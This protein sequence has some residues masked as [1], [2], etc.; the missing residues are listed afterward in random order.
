[1]TNELFTNNKRLCCSSGLAVLY[2]EDSAPL[3]AVSQQLLKTR[4]VLWRTDD[5]DIPNAC[6][7][8]RGKGIVNHRFIINW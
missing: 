3:A 6:Q 7:H 4:R 5:Q 2:I 1:M 8:K